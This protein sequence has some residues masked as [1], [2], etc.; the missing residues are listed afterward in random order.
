MVNAAVIA[1]SR[2]MELTTSIREKSGDYLTEINLLVETERRKREVAGTLYGEQPRIV[3]VMGTRIEASILVP[4]TRTIL[5]C[6]PYNVPA[7]S[8][9]LLSVSTKR[10]ISVR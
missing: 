8:L 5:G 4:I 6:S 9:F 2:N 1:K 7:T 10:L 3:R